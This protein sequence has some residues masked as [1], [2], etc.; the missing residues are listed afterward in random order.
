LDPN[1]LDRATD[2]GIRI[3]TKMSRIPCRVPY[4][5]PLPQVPEPGA[6]LLGGR[7]AA[8]HA[9]VPET[10]TAGGGAT[11]G[12]PE[13]DPAQSGVQAALRLQVLL[14]FPFPV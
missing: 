1:P 12:R 7:E 13:D 10:E 4:P 11:R 3:R 5:F 14:H 2:P 6:D 9:G 8:E